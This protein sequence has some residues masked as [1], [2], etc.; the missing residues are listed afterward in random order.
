MNIGADYNSSW[1]KGKAEER[2]AIRK[3]KASTKVKD[4]TAPTGKGGYPIGQGNPFQQGNPFKGA[5]KGK[6]KHP[7]KKHERKRKIKGKDPCYKCGQQGH[8]AKNCRVAV[9]N[10]GSDEHQ[11]WENDPSY[12]WYQDQYQ[13][14][15]DQGWYNQDWTQQG[16]EQGYQQPAAS[17][18]S[19]PPT[20]TTPPGM[21]QSISA[22]EDTYIATLLSIN[23]IGQP[24][25]T[26]ESIMIDSGA[27]THVCPPWFGT[28]LPL[29]LVKQQDKPIPRTVT[30]T[31]IWAYGYRWI[32]F[33][34]QRGQH[35]VIP[36]YVCDVKQPILS[37]TRLIHQGFEINMSGK[38]D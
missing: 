22:M 32:L 14:G 35:I 23:Q 25:A 21:A 1:H 2:R 11:Q 3:E 36:F 38:I 28:S 29:H 33:I 34:N 24:P 19:P 31:D 8:I 6:G 27:A 17:S 13:Q 10:V 20:S 18:Q 16:Y 30:G 26:E 4:T 7:Q 15:Y 5:S 9:Y 12:D 37:V